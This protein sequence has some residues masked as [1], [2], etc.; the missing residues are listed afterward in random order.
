MG[1]QFFSHG[2][3]FLLATEVK[4]FVPF[5]QII[6]ISKTITVFLRVRAYQLKIIGSPLKV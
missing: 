5:F 3:A 1:R 6:K 2:D 4:Y